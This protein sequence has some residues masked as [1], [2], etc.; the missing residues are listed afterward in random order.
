MGPVDDEEP[1]SAGSADGDTLAFYQSNADAYAG[2]AKPNPRLGAFLALLPPG[3]TVLELGCGAGSDS[4]QMLAAG[5]DVHPTD[6]SAEMAAQA[7][8][9]LGRPVATL[10]FHELD[11]QGAYDAV[12]ASF[13]LLHVPRAGLPDV[14]TRVWRALRPGGHLYASFKGGEAEGRDKLGRYYSYPS[15]DWLRG[16]FQAAGAWGSFAIEVSEDRGYDGAP[17]MILHIVAQKA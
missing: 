1:T 5:F 14:L 16:T 6:G 4:A 7:S 13:C 8:R 2:W 12:W 17:A 15:Q 11:E 10:L 9:R 3:A